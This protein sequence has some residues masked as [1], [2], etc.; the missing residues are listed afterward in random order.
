MD[1][2]EYYTHSQEVNSGGLEFIKEGDIVWEKDPYT[3]VYFIR[4]YGPTTIAYRRQ[5]KLHIKNSSGIITKANA[6]EAFATLF[7]ETG[8]RMYGAFVALT[9]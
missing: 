1:R 7:T 9:T 5:R 2:L 8:S 4:N 3:G 6:D